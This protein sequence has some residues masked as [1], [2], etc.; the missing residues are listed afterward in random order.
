[1][2]NSDF[3]ATNNA[4]ATYNNCVPSITYNYI[5]GGHTYTKYC[6]YCP[7][8]SNFQGGSTSSGYILGAIS[9]FWTGNIMHKWP[10]GTYSGL[11]GPHTAYGAY[12]LSKLEED[13]VG[14]DMFGPNVASE[15]KDLELEEYAKNIRDELSKALSE[16]MIDDDITST[17]STDD[18]S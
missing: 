2:Q 12:T 17:S 14:S 6:L 15:L 3:A 8:T 13:S 7:L 9:N 10:F 11:G 5:S 18:F 4:A 16:K 1:M